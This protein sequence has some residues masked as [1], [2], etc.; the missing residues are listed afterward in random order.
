[1]DRIT[2]TA[3]MLAGDADDCLALLFSDWWE[4]MESMEPSMLGS[5]MLCRKECTVSK[6]TSR[7]LLTFQHEKANNLGKG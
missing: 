2:V 5:R 7:L 3:E 1:M 4:S 6:I